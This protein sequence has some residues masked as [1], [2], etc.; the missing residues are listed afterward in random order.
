MSEYQ[1]LQN[2]IAELQI[3]AASIRD[4]ERT[5]AIT[6]INGLIE[7]FDIKL[8]ELANK[9]GASARGMAK[10]MLGKKVKKVAPR[11]R[12]SHGNEWTGRGLQPKWLRAA[13]AG[14][15]TLESFLIPA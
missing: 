3:K 10:P 7:S 1:I 4:A 15:A 2:Q 5:A 12:D 8:S 14:G 11:Y 6:Q 13:I 9:A